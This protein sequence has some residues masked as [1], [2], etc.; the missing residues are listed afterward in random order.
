MPAINYFVSDL[1]NVIVGRS[2]VP[3]WKGG[4]VLE[5][6]FWKEAGVYRFTKDSGELKISFEDA[7]GESGSSSKKMIEAQKT[8][9][10]LL[11]KHPSVK[12]KSVQSQNSNEG[13]LVTLQLENR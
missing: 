11:R 1:I 2:T 13:F 10:K 6:S 7:V 5:Y 4:R 12:L 9:E 8:T 3:V